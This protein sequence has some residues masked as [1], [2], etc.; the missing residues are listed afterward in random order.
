M[1]QGFPVRA[2][3]D[4][5]E[6]AHAAR[7]RAD[8][9]EGGAFLYV[10]E[11]VLP[12]RRHD[13]AERLAD[14]LGVLAAGHDHAFVADDQDIAIAVIEMFIDLFGQILQKIEAQIRTGHAQKFSV[15]FDGHGQRGQPILLAL[16]GVGEGVEHAFLA[17]L[18][19]AEIPAA[20]ADAVVVF[21]LVFIIHQGLT[22]DFSLF[23][24]VPI[25][26]EAAPR[27]RS[28]SWPVRRIRRRGHPGHSV[29]RRYRCRDISDCFPMCC[30]RYH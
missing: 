26:N 13:G 24:A 17:R 21:G 19:R 23:V 30:A 29:P 9:H 25:G 18:P 5:T 12:A 14:G 6:R 10:P 28:R 3:L 8:I 7:L 22:G 20:L 1:H 27:R 11:H 16:D 4:R 15:H 2:E